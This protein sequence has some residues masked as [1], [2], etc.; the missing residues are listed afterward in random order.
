[1]KKI[2]LIALTL[3]ASYTMAQ[4]ADDALRY[5]Q[6]QVFGTARNTAMGGSFGAL[7]GDISSASIN[8]AGLGVYR[9]SEVNG[10]L[11]LFATNHSAS[12]N[13]FRRDDQKMNIA[14]GNIGL[15]G[16][17]MLN[18]NPNAGGWVSTTFAFGYNRTNNFHSNTLI[19]GEN[20]SSSL[21]DVF[22]AQ[23]N[24]R[25]NNLDLF[26]SELA[27]DANLIFIADSVNNQPVF[28]SD[29]PGGGQGIIQ[30]RTINTTGGMGET[31]FSFAGN[32]DDKL[33]LGATIAYTS[34]RFNYTSN[35]R[36]ETMDNEFL[37]SYNY[38]EDFS[39]RGGGFNLKFG[40]LFRPI[41]WIRLGASVH[42]PTFLSLTD[43][44]STSIDS[45]F[46][47][48][49]SHFDRSVDSQIGNFS[50]S[51]TTPMRATGSVGFVILKSGLINIDY[52]AI[53]YSSARFSSRRTGNFGMT[54]NEQIRGSLASTGNLR[55]GAEW[56][57]DPF[58]I[59]AGYG[60]MGNPYKTE[61]NRGGSNNFSLG[62]GIREKEYYLDFAYMLSQ[63]RD[64]QF[65]MYDPGI[66]GV[67]PV[68]M[69]KNVNTFLATVGFRF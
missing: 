25:P 31:F 36:E 54:Q 17:T 44:F 10:T 14:M 65:F 6:Q 39:T 67:N 19:T 45:R 26:G 57:L 64:H 62:F 24:A 68:L 40:F 8:P 12:F 7:G 43:N 15:V 41:D 46:Q 30:N 42:T 9:S 60:R 28:T 56:R 37:A 52:E 5:S 61:V 69:N 35:H 47:S 48:A 2:Y 22:V 21:L 29:I 63:V 33:Y 58:A 49:H 66:T 55:I 50:Y 16:N 53:D 34:V 1:M 51:L 13:G 23:A 3:S 27:Y 11:G 59:R 18:D 32:Y 38:Y 4:N 20:F